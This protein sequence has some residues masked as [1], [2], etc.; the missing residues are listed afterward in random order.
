MGW[1]KEN[2]DQRPEPRYEKPLK[3]SSCKKCLLCGKLI[4]MSQE[5]DCYEQVEYHPD[6]DE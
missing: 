3:N 5:C 6:G 1:W 4:K 2:E